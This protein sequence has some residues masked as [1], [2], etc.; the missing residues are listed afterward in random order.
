M[1]ALREFTG[2]DAGQVN[3]LGL[4]AFEA[5]RN[6]YT[7]WPVFRAR[8]A[9]MSS[10]ADAGEIIVA[11]QDG[12]IIGAV[13]YIG[14]GKPKQAMFQPEWP[15][16]RML[17]GAPEAQGQGI[18]RALAQECIRRALRDGAGVFALHTSELMQRALPMYERM[19]FVRR[20][21]APDIH[22]VKYGIYVKDL[23]AHR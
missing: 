7:D 12:R 21:D 11:Q 13:A 23:A 5:Y 16:M 14:P 1:F 4:A 10:L 17:V 22:G 6:A 2:A 18:G 9:T 20:S 3:A 15:I 19:G 8:I